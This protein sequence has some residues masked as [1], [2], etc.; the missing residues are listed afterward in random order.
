MRVEVDVFAQE[1]NAA[2]VGL[3]GVDSR[4]KATHSGNSIMTPKFF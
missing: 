4:I 1:W 3:M 2:V